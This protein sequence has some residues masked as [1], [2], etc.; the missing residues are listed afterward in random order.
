MDRARRRPLRLLAAGAV[1]ALAAAACG[2]DD[3]GSG[4]GEGLTGEITISGSS[5]VEPIST[6]VAQKFSSQNPDVAI[7]VDGPGTGDGFELFCQGETDVSDA[8][9]PIEEEEAA[10]CEEAGI[11]Y[12]ELKV[13]IDGITVLTS[14]ENGDV[15]CLDFHDLY[16]LLGPESEG[17][18]SWSDANVLA[19][20]IGAGNTPYPDA[21]LDVTAPGEESGTYDS[22]AELVLED[23]A[24]EERGIPE[25]DAVIRPDYQASGNDNVI[26][27]GIEGSSSSL[28]WVG[29]AYF[30]QAGDTV[31][32][33]EID[34]GDGCVAPTTETIADGS[35]PIARE[36][37]VY[38]NS[39]AAEEKPALA[40]FVDYYLSE[41]GLAS[42]A[43]AGY[44]DLPEDE[45]QASVEAWGS[46]ETGTREG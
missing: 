37:F 39:A 20:E 3:T 36:L 17:F 35:Y 31:K 21:P 16:A 42:V 23:I 40:A 5:T 22:F 13:G 41:E 15:T 14:P 19:A 8:S 2:G 34:G 26:L 10:A 43:E 27:Q 24:Y 32:A 29:F 46:M 38:V 44:V 18:E 25:D 7:S 28:G 4:G 33:I 6:L 9:R 1:V 30:E 45:M 12:V 11:E